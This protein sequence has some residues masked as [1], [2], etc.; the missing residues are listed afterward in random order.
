M[1]HTSDGEAWKHFD[2]LHQDKAA[3]PRNP[4]VCIATDGFNPF[5]MTATQY[6]CWHVFVIPLNLPPPRADYAKKE[7][8]S[9]VDNSRAQLSGEEYE[10]IPATA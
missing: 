1:V 10:C 6:S 4:R 3:D 8:I 9:D 5:G 2:G 7:H